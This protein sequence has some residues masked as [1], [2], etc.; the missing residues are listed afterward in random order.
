[1]APRL[2]EVALV[3]HGWHN[4]VAGDV[5]ARGLVSMRAMPALKVAGFDL[6]GFERTEAAEAALEA[7]SQA[8]PQLEVGYDVDNWRPPTVTAWPDLDARFVLGAPA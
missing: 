6:S 1:M 2:Q 8:K 5:A 3:G 7:L 4:K